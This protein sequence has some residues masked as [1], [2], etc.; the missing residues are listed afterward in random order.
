MAA[1][2]SHLQGERESL[3]RHRQSSSQNLSNFAKRES[4]CVCVRER[5]RER[6][7]MQ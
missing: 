5:E 7:I 2:A 3:T 4:V 6:E 1:E